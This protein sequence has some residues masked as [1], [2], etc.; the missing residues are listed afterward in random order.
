M[1]EDDHLAKVRVAGS[2]PVVLSTR[3]S[4]SDGKIGVLVSRSAGHQCS[5]FAIARTQGGVGAFDV[6]SRQSTSAP[7]GVVH[8]GPGSVTGGQGL[9]YLCDPTRL[10]GVLSVRHGRTGRIVGLVKLGWWNRAS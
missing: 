4:S 10:T 9:R 7:G 3:R 6:R 5:R 1:D 8:F 2:N